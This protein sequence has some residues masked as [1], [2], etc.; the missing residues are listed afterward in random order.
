TELFQN[1]ER[2]QRGDALADW[3]QFL[4]RAA[5]E[6]TRQQFHPVNA[7]VCQILSRQMRAVRFGKGRN[8][9]RQL[10]TVKRFTAGFDNQLQRDRRRRIT[11][12]I[13]H[14]W[15]TAFWC[16]TGAEPGLIFQLVVSALPEMTNQW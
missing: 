16:D 15:R 3:R 11:V 7:M 5:R 12:D 4:N 6:I 9:L 1:T 10:A 8:F 2:N 13:A 14:S